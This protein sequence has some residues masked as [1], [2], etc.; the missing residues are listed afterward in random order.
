[1]ALHVARACAV[2]YRNRT[3]QVFPTIFGPPLRCHL[4]FMPRDREPW[5]VICKRCSVMMGYIG[6]VFCVSILVFGKSKLLN[7]GIVDAWM[8]P[9]LFADGYGSAI[10]CQLELEKDS[11]NSCQQVS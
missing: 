2:A 1:M 7:S 9:P 5:I 6:T 10:S 3:A 8:P 4:S 11:T